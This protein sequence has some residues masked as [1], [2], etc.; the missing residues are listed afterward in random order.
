MPPLEEKG[1]VPPVLPG[2]AGLSQ[3]AAESHPRQ[4]RDGASPSC[5]SGPPPALPQPESGGVTICPW[6]VTGSWLP[7]SAGADR[8]GPA[9]T[10]ML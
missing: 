2:E 7:A 1:R 10:G 8:S 9:P 6:K 5:S 4:A 3:E